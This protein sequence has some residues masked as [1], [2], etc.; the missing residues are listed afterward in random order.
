MLA[1]EDINPALL[2]L[3]SRLAFPGK[4]FTAQIS[5]RSNKATSPTIQTE[6]FLRVRSITPIGAEETRKVRID[7]ADHF[8]QYGQRRVIYELRVE[9]LKNTDAAWAWSA[10][11]RIRTR[12]W[13]PSSLEV[14][15]GLN[16]ALLD[17][18]TALDLPSVRDRR[19]WSIAAMDVT[20]GA[21]FLDIEDAPYNWI[22]RVEITS[23]VSDVDAILLPSPP[24]YTDL[25]EAP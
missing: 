4:Q 20:F 3:V 7:G 2:D 11:E 16:M 5:G 10:M 8:A 17:T 19:E 23:Q 12:L 13:R 21:A 24:N 9:S 22:Q 1:W 25:I 6:I 14:L 15:A 18:G